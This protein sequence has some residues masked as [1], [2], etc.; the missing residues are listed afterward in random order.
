MELVNFDID[1]FMQ[2]FSADGLGFPA[3]LQ[4]KLK[5]EILFVKVVSYLN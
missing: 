2:I 5:Q 1:T 4:T 3:A